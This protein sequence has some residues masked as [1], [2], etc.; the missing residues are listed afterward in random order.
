MDI[1]KSL[2]HAMINNDLKAKDVAELTG[3]NTR[4]ITNMYKLPTCSNSSLKK[5]AEAFNM[6]VS[7]FIALGE[8]KCT[9]QKA[10]K[11]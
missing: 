7:E 3:L 11:K 2:R 8:Y 10:L 5:L 6:S 9:N 4:T 1:G